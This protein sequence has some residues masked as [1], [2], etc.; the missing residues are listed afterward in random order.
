MLI[1]ELSHVCVAVSARALALPP[2]ECDAGAALRRESLPPEAASVHLGRGAALAALRFP[3]R[4]KLAVAVHE[5]LEA[6]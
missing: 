5:R 3:G 1:D 2:H 6:E 4:D